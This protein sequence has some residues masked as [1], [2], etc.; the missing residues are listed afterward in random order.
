MIHDTLVCDDINDI[1]V[2]IDVIN[3]IFVTEGLAFN[4]ILFQT[5]ATLLW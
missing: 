3:D 5:V 2:F 1:I 4:L